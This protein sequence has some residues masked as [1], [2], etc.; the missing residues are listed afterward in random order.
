MKP[1]AVA[2]TMALALAGCVTEIDDKP[3]I[4][5]LNFAEAILWSEPSE[6]IVELHH[7]AGREP[8]EFGLER[9]REELQALTSKST[10]TILPSVEIQVGDESDDRMWTVSELYSLRAQYFVGHGP[11]QQTAK[12]AWLSED[13]VYIHVMFLNGLGQLEEDRYFVGLQTVPT[14][15]VLADHTDDL[16]ATGGS[17]P[18]GRVSVDD[19]SDEPIGHAESEAAILI[20]ELGH[21]IGLVGREAPMLTPRLPSA[22]DDQCQCHSNQEDSVMFAGVESLTL[23]DL[24]N[25]EGELYATYTFDGFDIEDVESLRNDDPYDK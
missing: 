5:H 17:S 19:P 8:E 24:Q 2:I 15:F 7:V 6:V 16:I 3:P 20:H 1:L 12:G 9:M 22:N 13:A 11:A 4:H 23:D 21:A 10:I 18:T 14:L 25:P